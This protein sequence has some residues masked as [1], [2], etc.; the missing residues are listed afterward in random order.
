MIPLKTEYRYI[1][2]DG[3]K[4]KMV[5]LSPKERK[6]TVPGILWIHGGGYATGYASMVQL[7]MGKVLAEHYGA[8]VLSPD[9]TLSLKKPYP[10]ALL[11]CYKALKYLFDNAEEL[12]VDTNRIIVGGESAGGG[13]CTALCLYARDRGEIPISFQIP[14][15]PML[16]CEDTGS[17]RDN[18]GHIW[19]TKKNHQ[20]WDLYLKG[21]DR[22][23]VPAYA[24]VSRVKDLSDMPPCYTYVE[25]GEP[26][27]EETLTYIRRL[28]EAG[29]EAKADVYHGNT[30]GFDLFLFTENARKAKE[31]LLAETEHLFR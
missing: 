20:A 14:L 28:N 23:D 5:L 31:R 3:R 10:A 26:F 9:Y 17:S 18:H 8:V 6:G 29:I 13:L 27:Y 16:D 12:G 15:Y 11:D 2:S 4:M 19:N 21:I 25:D 22:N 7:S 1:D 30:H 24:S